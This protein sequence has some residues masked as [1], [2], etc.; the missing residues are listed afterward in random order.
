MANLKTKICNI[1][2]PNPIWTA[3]GPTS[4]NAGMLRQAAEGGAGGLV[5][6]TI[7]VQPARVPIPNIYS[8]FAGSLL[9]AELWSEMDY[10]NFIDNQLP[11]IKALELPVIA[12]LGYSPDDLKLL[13]KGLEKSG[14][15]DAIEFSIHYIGKDIENLKQ[16]ASALK[17]Q[18]SVPVFAKLS[19][20]ISDLKSVIQALDEIV[21]GY[22]AINSVGPALDFN[23]ETLQPYLGSQDGRGWLSGRA[24]LPIGLHFVA[25]IYSLSK[26]PVIGVGGISSVQDVVKYLMSG[27]SAVQICSLAILKGQQVCGELAK[28]LSQWMDEHGYDDIESLIGIIHRKKDRKQYFLNEGDQLYPLIQT[29]RCNFCDRCVR[30]CIHHAIRFEEQEFLVDRSRCVSCGLCVSL[31]PKSALKLIENFY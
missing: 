27:A 28:E 12:S 16:T 13:G 4:A 26:K 21:D 19:P 6:K 29:E 11:Q 22:V 2:F 9:N 30:S 1:E 7:S 23:I 14:L 18:V 10:R 5:T 3:A 25:S 31:C 8:P 17:Q 20:S 24:I 15:A